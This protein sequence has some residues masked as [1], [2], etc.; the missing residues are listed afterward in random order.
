MENKACIFSKLLNSW[1]LLNFHVLETLCAKEN[2]FENLPGLLLSKKDDINLGFDERCVVEAYGCFRPLQFGEKKMERIFFWRG[3]ASCCMLVNLMCYCSESQRITYSQ[4]IL[5]R[6]SVCLELKIVKYL[7][8]YFYWAVRPDLLQNLK[9][10]LTSFDNLVATDYFWFVLF[11]CE[12]FSSIS[13][14]KCSQGFYWIKFSTLR[15][16]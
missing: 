3:L 8:W 10:L 13:C 11:C 7:M 16:A 14:K 15:S 1:V 6:L 9:W 4:I 5:I 12:F 2:P